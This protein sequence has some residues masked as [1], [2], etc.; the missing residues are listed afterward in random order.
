MK[1]N[2]GMYCRELLE[3]LLEDYGTFCAHKK[4]S[5]TL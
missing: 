5:V 3:L 2:G 1:E 4:S